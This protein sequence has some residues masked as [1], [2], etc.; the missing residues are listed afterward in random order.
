MGL[1]ADLGRRVYTQYKD[2]DRY[3]RILSMA[4][5]SIPVRF[6]LLIRRFSDVPFSFVG[7]SDVPFS[8]ISGFADAGFQDDGSAGFT[9]LGA[10]LGG[11]GW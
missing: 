2:L 11:V 4:T 9:D 7:F 5:G 10:T 6:H 3:R 8:F 1:H